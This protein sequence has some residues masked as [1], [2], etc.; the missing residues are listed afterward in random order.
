MMK[1]LV[2]FCHTR[3][4]QRDHDQANEHNPHLRRPVVPPPNPLQPPAA[5]RLGM[6]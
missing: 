4:Q 2:K 5:R 6:R 3:S 1:L